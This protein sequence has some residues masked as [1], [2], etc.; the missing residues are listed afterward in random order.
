MLALLLA[1]AAL[2]AAAS[3][4]EETRAAAEKGDAEAQYELADAYFF[5]RGVPRDCEKTVEWRRKA[6]DQGHAGALY[7][8]GTYALRPRSCLP[9][10]HAEA[11]RWFLLAAERGDARAM[12]ALG[13]M[14]LGGL[15]TPRDVVTGRR[16]LE[17]A[18]HR[19]AE[20][21]D[22]AE[23][24]LP[25]TRWSCAVPAVKACRT[26]SA[27]P[28]P[29]EEASDSQAYAVE[30][31]CLAAWIEQAGKE[32]REEDAE[33]KAARARAR[34]VAKKLAAVFD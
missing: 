8:L 32:G 23:E 27:C 2:S 26:G 11:R 33:Y 19:G 17:K 14:D 9:Q 24:P 25:T 4:L 30:L 1:V 34:L 6:A 20:A 18:A 16:W 5:G 31:K 15:G 29:P 28:D 3:T 10:D 12:R 13:V 22:T 21:E 7:D